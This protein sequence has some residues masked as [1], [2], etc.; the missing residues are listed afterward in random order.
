MDDLN[1]FF[2]GLLIVFLYFGG[3][4]LLVRKFKRRAFE[5][6]QQVEIASQRKFDALHHVCHALFPKECM[7]FYER[8]TKNEAFDDC[9]FEV[10]VPT[11]ISLQFTDFE[12]A[13]KSRLMRHVEPSLIQDALDMTPFTI[14]VKN[15][16]SIYPEL[17]RLTQ[18]VEAPEN[19][20]RRLMLL[21]HNEARALNNMIDSPW[22]WLSAKL[23]RAQKYPIYEPSKGGQK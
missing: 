10:V 5:L 19:D 18:L 1:G 3:M 15:T 22:T 13:M 20:F 2:I 8:F 6:H 16:L 17:I 14:Q 9:L 23:V 7:Q 21:Y 12:K 11:D 4:A